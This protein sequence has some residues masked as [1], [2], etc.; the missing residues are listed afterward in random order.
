[1]YVF[2]LIISPPLGSSRMESNIH[3]T[4]HLDTVFSENE[5]VAVPEATCF[6]SDEVAGF[7]LLFR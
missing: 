3:V 1:M 6:V 4:F 5:V 2:Y 7:P